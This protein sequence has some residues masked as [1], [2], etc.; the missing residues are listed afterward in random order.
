MKLRPLIVSAIFAVAMAACEKAPEEH[1]GEHSTDSAD[2]REPIV[3]SAPERDHVLA[4]MRQMLQS[5]EGVVSWLAAGDMAAVAAA[6]ALS[7]RRA[8]MTVD[9]TLHLK[10]PEKFLSM[11]AA[12]HGGFDDIARMAA[13]G[14]SQQG[15]EKKLGEVLRNCTACHAAYRVELH[16]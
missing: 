6:A 13:D 11:G 7:G 4:E 15:V 8:P 2:L 5:T 1:E 3:L 16:D 9:Q 12:A 10:F 14:E